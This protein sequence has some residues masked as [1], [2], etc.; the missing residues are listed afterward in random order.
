MVAV[1][2]AAVALTQRPSKQEME[3]N[4][5]GKH[6]TR[7]GVYKSGNQCAWPL[8]LQYEFALRIVAVAAVAAAVL[9]HNILSKQDNETKQGWNQQSWFPDLVH[10]KS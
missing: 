3:S 6:K 7:P 9:S 4:H 5:V 8:W 10:A 1:A 2:V